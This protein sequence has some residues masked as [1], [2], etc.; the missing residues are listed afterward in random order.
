MNAALRAD[1]D[2]AY[3]RVFELLDD[4]NAVEVLRDHTPPGRRYLVD[5]LETALRLIDR[6]ADDDVEFSVPWDDDEE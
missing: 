6:I 1:Y 3:L 5:R 4:L 2:A